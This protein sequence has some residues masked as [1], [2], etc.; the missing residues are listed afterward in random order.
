MTGI[1]HSYFDWD[2]SIPDFL[3][4]LRL[5]LQNQEIDPAGAGANGRAQALGY[6]RACMRERTLEWFDK[7]IITKTN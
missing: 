1:P 2:D 4:Q 3:A 5:D 7:E 6:L